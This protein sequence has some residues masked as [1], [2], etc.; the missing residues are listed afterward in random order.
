ML[1]IDLKCCGRAAEIVARIAHEDLTIL[2][3]APNHVDEIG[4]F[5]RKRKIRSL[6]GFTLVNRSLT[7]LQINCPHGSRILEGKSDDTLDLLCCEKIVSERR[8]TKESSE[9]L[10]AIS[11]TFFFVF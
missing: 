4:S 7:I 3:S 1:H 10:R 6:L 5:H 8:D 2:I 9:Y 11:N